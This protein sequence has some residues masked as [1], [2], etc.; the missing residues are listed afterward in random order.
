MVGLL[1]TC[2][3]G[4]GDATAPSASAPRPPSSEELQAAPKQLASK[5]ANARL[6]ALQ[7]LVT[8]G[9]PQ[10]VEPLLRALDAQP[11]DEQALAVL[12][13][14]LL[15]DERAL[16]PLIK[17][18]ETSRDELVVGEVAWALG[19]FPADKTRAPLAAIMR[20]ARSSSDRSA[21]QAAAS[22]AAL[23]DAEAN[24]AV[25]GYAAISMPVLG[26]LPPGLLEQTSPHDPE[27]AERL[28]LRPQCD[29]AAAILEWS[30]LP[31][32]EGARGLY[33]SS[34]LLEALPEGCDEALRQSVAR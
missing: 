13:L 27:L 4:A 14:G 19:Q 26:E 30:R 29:A 3:K 22:L 11:A 34:D 21:E 23:G 24:A 8:S 6:R 16:A 10:A 15:R 12:G 1:S 5:D 7:L 28:A 20:R 2:K 31:P 18:S 25:L 17:L 9:S 32:P 33:V